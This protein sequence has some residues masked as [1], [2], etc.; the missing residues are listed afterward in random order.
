MERV[1]IERRFAYH[2]PKNQ[3]TASIHETVRAACGGLALELS[4]LVPEGR[5]LHLAVT[6]IEEAMMWA[7]AGI[8][9]AAAG[10]G[11]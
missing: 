5:E 2:R 9:R 8:A 6:K 1:D 4:L 7:N 10:S 3:E 11:D